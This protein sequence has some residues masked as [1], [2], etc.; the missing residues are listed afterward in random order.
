LPLLL[1]LIENRDNMDIRIDEVVCD[2]R[3]YMPLLLMADEQESM[4]ERYLD[5]G[6]MFVM[7]DS[8]TPIAVCVV[9]DEGADICELKNLAV[10]PSYRKHGFGAD[11]I[12][13]VEQL[14]AS[15]GFA[16]MQVG[17][18][19]TPSTM[20]FYRSCGF[21]ISHRIPAFFRMNYDHIIVEEGVTL[22]DMVYLSKPI[23]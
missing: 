20:R 18:G 8:D 22:C 1:F 6:R 5:R 14:F 15:E 2:K 4:V 17:T 19:E 3:E 7:R 10:V 21:C 9:T 23:S 12:R 11:M 16:V 13:H